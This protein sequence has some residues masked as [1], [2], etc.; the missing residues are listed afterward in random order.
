MKS[1][2]KAMTEHIKTQ[3]YTV[4]QFDRA[5]GKRLGTIGACNP[6]RAFHE[7]TRTLLSE[8]RVPVLLPGDY[9][10]RSKSDITLE[11]A[12]RDAITAENCM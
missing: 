5:T 6:L 4:M 10:D 8:N 11:Q 7:I 9:A 12:L 3:R 1:T 2:I